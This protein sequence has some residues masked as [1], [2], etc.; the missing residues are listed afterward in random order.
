[1]GYTA[2]CRPSIPLASRALLQAGVPDH[3]IQKELKG[4]VGVGSGDGM[5]DGCLNC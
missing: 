2:C 1:M 3:E 5:E 4:V